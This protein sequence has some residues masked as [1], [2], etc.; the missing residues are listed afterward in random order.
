MEY[1]IILC[2]SLSC[3]LAGATAAPSKEEASE[4]SKEKC[5][6][7]FSGC[8][9]DSGECVCGETIDCQNPFPYKDI[10]QCKKDLKGLLDKCLREPCEHGQCVQ[11]K[12]DQSRRW[13]CSCAGSGF[14][15][16]KCEIECPTYD[17]DKV[18]KG[19]PSDCIY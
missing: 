15:G 9:V 12:K 19:F 7:L 16:K 18:E 6:T 11:A 3:L 8:S 5:S 17:E 13:V 4:V 2:L 1:K 10:K 14:Y